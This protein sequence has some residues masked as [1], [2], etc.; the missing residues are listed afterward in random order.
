MNK[1]NECIGIFYWN[2]LRR[3]LEKTL[4]NMLIGNSTI[5]M[6]HNIVVY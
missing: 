1:V 3:K 4:Q 5:I 2:L 6:S